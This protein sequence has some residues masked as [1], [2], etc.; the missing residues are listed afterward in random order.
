MPTYSKNFIA[1]FRENKEQL[2][3]QDNAALSE[4]RRRALGGNPRLREIMEELRSMV[5]QS[6]LPLSQSIDISKIEAAKTG[7]SLDALL[8]RGYDSWQSERT[9][10]NAPNYNSWLADIDKRTE[11]IGIDGH[12]L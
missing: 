7:P 3:R 1:Y 5:D 8:N 11:T 2:L 12:P 4:S 10:V 6:I 9:A